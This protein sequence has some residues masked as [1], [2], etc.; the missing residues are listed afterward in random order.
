MPDPKK[1]FENYQPTPEQGEK[2]Q[3]VDS[4]FKFAYTVLQKLRPE[5]ADGNALALRYIGQAVDSLEEAWIKA[6]MAIIY[7]TG[8]QSA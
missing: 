5:K 1:R 8:G 7:N 4:T 3:E 6:K 2:I